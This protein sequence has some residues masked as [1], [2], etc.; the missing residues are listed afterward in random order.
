MA[1]AHFPATFKE[2]KTY[3]S[4]RGFR[5]SD[6]VLKLIDGLVKSY[7]SPEY[8]T[9]K[10]DI[11]YQLLMATDYWLKKVNRAER[12]VGKESRRNA[13]QDMNDLCQRKLDSK[14]AKSQ[15]ALQDIF[16]EPDGH[17]GL[18]DVGNQHFLLQVSEG[19]Q[20][21]DQVAASRGM[22]YF[23]EESDR[24]KFKLSFRGGLAY[25]WTFVMD[26]Q[27][28]ELNLY[29]T[30]QFN[31]RGSRKGEDDV[32]LFVM[33]TNEHIYAGVDKTKYRSYMHSYFF[34]GAPVLCAGLMRV[35]NGRVVTV[36]GSSGHYGPLARHMIRLLTRLQLYQ[37][38]MSR[39]NVRRVNENVAG[40]IEEC[41]AKDFIRHR[42]WPT[43]EQPRSMYVNKATL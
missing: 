10:L 42:G 13:I 33:G 39:L 36:S 30:D 2:W 5:N 23:T 41:S 19:L 32:G 29:D 17:G 9:V 38:D 1:L 6:P 22:P 26:D 11:L 16:E 8:R 15:M 20:R 21:A 25:R 37:V 34:A 12:F 31:D 24:R 14:L 7:R 3:S 43:G 35:E 4:A 28:S 18:A 27:K 40:D